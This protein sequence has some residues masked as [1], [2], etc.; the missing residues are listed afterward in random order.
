MF[1]QFICF[2]SVLIVVTKICGLGDDEVRHIFYFTLSVCCFVA[3]RGSCSSSIELSSDSGILPKTKMLNFFGVRCSS[4]SHLTTKMKDPKMM[5]MT[6]V[7]VAICIT[8]LVGSAELVA[9]AMT[10]WAQIV[11]LLMFCVVATF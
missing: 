2:L 7:S 9:R 1:Q 6:T 4:A 8:R 11:C 3:R 10:Y 5:P